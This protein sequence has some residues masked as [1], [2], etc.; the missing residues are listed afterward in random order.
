MKSNQ[1]WRYSR[2]TK[3]GEI[4]FVRET[5][6]FLEDVIKYIKEEKGVITINVNDKPPFIIFYTKQGYKIQYFWTSGRWAKMFEGRGLPKK[7]YLSFNIKDL[8]ERFL[9]KDETI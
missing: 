2:K 6:E 8:F 3:D 1:K 9:D 5:N 7:H 4:K